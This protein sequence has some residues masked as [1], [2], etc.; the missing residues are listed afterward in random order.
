MTALERTEVKTA[1]LRLSDHGLRWTVP[2]GV[3]RLA[4]SF[5]GGRSSAIMTRLV[6]E[7]CVNRPDIEIA[8]VFA[9]TGAE[10]TE[11][12][13]FVERCQKQ[14]GFPVTWV[15]AEI[16]PEHGKGVRHRIVDSG[17]ASRTGRPFRD[18]VAKHGVP[19]R[20]Q[21]QCTT[22]LKILPM[23]SFIKRGLG[24]QR[25][26][27]HTCIGIRADEIDRMSVRQEELGILYPLID[28]DVVK[29]QVKALMRA[30]GFDLNLPGDHYGNCVTCYKKTKRKLLT[31]AQDDPSHF[32]LFR[33]LESE[34]GSVKAR[35]ERRSF[36]M[37]NGNVFGVEDILREAESF[38][39]SRRYSDSRQRTLWDEALDFGSGCGESCE[40]DPGLM[41][42]IEHNGGTE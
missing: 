30:T 12:L 34:F 35:D 28:C 18:F 8:V 6:I 7:A 14:W 36:F 27:Y 26:K 2:P 32:D 17:T 1:K 3:E 23:E 31:I 5:S 16:N 9:N 10:H 15:E 39:R 37:E 29:E 38:P 42:N 24:W 20:A 13:S 33:M 11:T 21:P 22:R 4:V 19:S 40:V 25:G 41:S